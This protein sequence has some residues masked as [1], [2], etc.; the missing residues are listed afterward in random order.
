MTGKPQPERSIPPPH[1]DDR[2]E[3]SEPRAE[4]RPEVVERLFR[5]HNKALLTFISSR[6]NSPSEAREIAQEAYV[7]LLGLNDL[8]AVSYLQ[9][10][11]YRIAGN[12]IA[13]RMRRRETRTRHEHFVFFDEIDRENDIPSPEV[14]SIEQQER[15]ILEV[16]VGELPPRLRLAFIRVELEGRSVKE[17]AAELHIKPESVRQFVHRS[18][19]FL[20]DALADRAQGDRR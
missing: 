18:Y 7:K 11:L 2:T 19:E 4:S 9:A 12:L 15:Q 5:E 13:D 10:Y 16:A 17:V 8:K 20:A 14:Q 6:L 3:R 1:S